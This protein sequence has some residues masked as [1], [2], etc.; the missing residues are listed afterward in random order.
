LYVVIL[1][2]ILKGIYSAFV[3]IGRTD[4]EYNMLYTRRCNQFGNTF[5][6]YRFNIKY[7]GEYM[8][9]TRLLYSNILRGI[10]ISVG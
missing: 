3:K 4:T 7:I 1:E 9:S 2:I 5:K 8:N 6:A 10:S